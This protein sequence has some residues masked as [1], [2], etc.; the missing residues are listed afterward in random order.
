MNGFNILDGEMN[1]VGTGIYL[2]VSITDH[3]CTPN[4]VATFEGTTLFI[5]MLED[6]PELDW[7]KIFISYIDLMN[8]PEDR[9]NELKM[10]YYFLC[11][12][13]KC[14]NGEYESLE[15]SLAACPN[16]KCTEPI[17]LSVFNGKTI[18]CKKCKTIVTDEY[19]QEFNE[20]M[21]FTKHH[22][23]NMKDIAYLDVCKICL[24]RQANLFHPLNLWHV[25]TLDMAF[26]SAI[27]IG[28]W[29]EALTYGKQLIPGFKK[30]NGDLN[31]LLG[32]L[33][34][35]IGKIQLYQEQMTNDA[36]N[37]LKNAANILKITHGD[38]HSLF[39][40]QLIPLLMEA[41]AVV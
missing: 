2:A 27:D 1:S 25:K 10:N 18:N 24:K 4:A 17:D 21:E 29:D 33:Y 13:T 30:Y 41:S 39:K 5:R 14:T 36:V 20:T 16:R 37:T 9:R 7:S 12:C 28:K 38:K 23:L 40:D 6:I 22:L 32:L 11:M 15:M 34:M 3:S 19:R 8:T 26:E 35:K 31:P